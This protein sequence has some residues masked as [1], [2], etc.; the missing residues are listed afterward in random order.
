MAP[1]NDLLPK[2]IEMVRQ[3]ARM[4]RPDEEIAPDRPLAELGVDSFALVELIVML[5][6]DLDVA[7]DEEHLTPEM[8]ESAQSIADALA[9]LPTAESR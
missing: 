5:E 3:C 2:V 1:G 4:L 7:L 8:F 9:A 6:E